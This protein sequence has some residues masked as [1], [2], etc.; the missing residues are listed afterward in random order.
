MTAPSDLAA[1]VDQM[2][3]VLDLPIPPAYRQ[4]VIDNFAQI[5]TI[6]Q[7]VLDFPLPE[8]TVAAPVFNPDAQP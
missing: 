7:Q 4:S 8:I 1:Y 6:A 5:T 3:I 2:A